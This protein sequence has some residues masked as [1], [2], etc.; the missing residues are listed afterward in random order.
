MKINNKMKKEE[1]GY[2]NILLFSATRANY[3]TELFFSKAHRVGG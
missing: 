1:E 3:F 2:T